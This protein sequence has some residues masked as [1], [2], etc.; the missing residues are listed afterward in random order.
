MA[1]STSISNWAFS[2]QK[3][4]RKVVDT[5]KC[6][7]RV[8]LI[9]YR[10]FFR[11]KISIRA[12]A[13]TYTIV[14]SMVP[15]LAMSTAVLKG[16]GSDNQL[17]LAADRFIETLEPTPAQIT[18]QKSKDY[19]AT[20]EEKT[21]SGTM[22]AHLHNAVDTI[23]SYVERTNFAALGA[24]GIIGL[25]V[26][27]IMLLSSVE[28]AMNAIWHT[29]KGRSIF[30]KVM[31]YLALLILLPI[32]IN[33]AL[34]GDAI[35]ESE[36][37]MA[38]IHTF[39]PSVWAVKM[40]LKLLPFLF[41]VLSLMAMYLFFPHVRVKTYA[42][43]SGA[44]FAAVFWF[45]VQRIYI[46]LQV[47]VANYNAIYGSF[48]TVPLFLVWLHLGWMF[49]LLGSTL[50]YAVQNRN[51]YQ[52]IAVDNSPQRQL[53]LT[54]DILKT[55][56]T[57]F[58]LRTPTTSSELLKEIPNARQVEVESVVLQLLEGGLIQK[59]N[60][61]K[62][63]LPITTADNLSGEEVVQVVLGNEFLPTPGGK[64]AT[65][66]ITV[67]GKTVNTNELFSQPTSEI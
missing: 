44:L 53:Q 36:K 50:A 18:E 29:K 52:Y 17:K 34:A 49:I 2:S 3:E 55:V 47:G 9:M 24:F 5:I 58:S 27:V 10:E 45:I 57:N 15:V 16:L 40:L 8:L 59:N 67:A 28:D 42:A 12:A 19:T 23:F 65:E 56:Y 20:E 4:N 30:R 38:Y 48:A 32:S 21:R 25:L 6:V 7:I 62:G 46:I 39:I 13:L 61:N 37:I 22:T 51:H 54:F 43:L 64:I 41:V 66:A 14:L 31:D 1:H 33:A 11:T 26:V 60:K 63:L 35:L